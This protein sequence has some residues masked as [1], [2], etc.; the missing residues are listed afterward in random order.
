MR[1]G[2]WVGLGHPE[3]GKMDM[4]LLQFQSFAMVLLEED[5][6]QMFSYTHICPHN[7]DLNDHQCGKKEKLANFKPGCA[8]VPVC[9]SH[10]SC[11]T[12]YFFNCS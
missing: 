7:L 12:S 11:E 4:T 2:A 9:L 6:K 3:N 5:C 10:R 8:D 1:V